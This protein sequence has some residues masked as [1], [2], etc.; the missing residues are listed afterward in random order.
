MYVTQD[1]GLLKLIILSFSRLSFPRAVAS[2]QCPLVNAT[3]R[4]QEGSFSTLNAWRSKA[5]E[6]SE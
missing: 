2:M 4:I 3:S 1:V 6:E 5:S